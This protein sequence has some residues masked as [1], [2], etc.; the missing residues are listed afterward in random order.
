MPI[1]SDP[2]AHTPSQSQASGAP[3]GP[4]PGRPSS[5]GSEGF[6]AIPSLAEFT[7]G[8]NLQ[9]RVPQGLANESG[10]GSSSNWQH[11][12]AGAQAEMVAREGFDYH[13][14]SSA[15]DAGGSSMSVPPE[16]TGR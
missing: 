15:E 1:G 12:A 13:Q 7:A 6:V 9:H 8:G 10:H 3:P 5:Q 2:R 11:A 4:T 16:P 14:Y